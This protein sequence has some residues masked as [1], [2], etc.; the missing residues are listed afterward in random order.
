MGWNHL[1][2]P[3]LQRLHRWSLGMDKQFHPTLYNGCNY[4]SMLGLK[5]NH[6]S[7][8]GHRR[9]K[10]HFVDSCLAL[11]GQSWGVCCIMKTMTDGVITTPYS[12]TAS[13]PFRGTSRLTKRKMS[14]SSIDHPLENLP[15]T[16]LGLSHAISCPCTDEPRSRDNMVLVWCLYITVT[17]YDHRGDSYDAR[18][19]DD[20]V[21]L[22]YCWLFF[23]WHV[24]DNINNP[25]A[26]GFNMEKMGKAEI[27]RKVTWMPT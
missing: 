27:F 3:K 9:R 10:C 20:H 11:P 23:Y 6:V 19:Y 4:L 25:G 15:L 14:T 17:S 7:K 16:D 21:T 22:L 8:R 1:S 2:I 18:S 13:V 24:Q 12:Y 5:L 26:L